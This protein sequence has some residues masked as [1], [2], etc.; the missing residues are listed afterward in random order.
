MISLLCALQINFTLEIKQEEGGAKSTKSD[1]AKKLPEEEGVPS[2]VTLGR[3]S[4]RY[5]RWGKITFAP[6]WT[7]RFNHHS[8]ILTLNKG[9]QIGG[10]TVDLYLA[11]ED[12]T[13]EKRL[14]LANTPF[15]LTPDKTVLFLSQP[16]MLEHF[17]G[18]V[19]RVG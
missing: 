1:A 7:V 10:V 5:L 19:L 8:R 15:Q 12:G 4:H 9:D 11:T 3:F 6:V 17:Q 18:K 13:E 2:N 14:D 16:E